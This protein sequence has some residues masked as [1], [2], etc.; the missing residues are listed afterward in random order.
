MAMSLQHFTIAIHPA[1][2]VDGCA[3]HIELLMPET[4]SVPFDPDSDSDSDPEFLPP[5]YDST[6]NNTRKTLRSSQSTN[7]Q[8]RMARRSKSLIG[9]M[10]PRTT[11]PDTPRLRRRF[12]RVSKMRGGVLGGRL[13]GLQGSRSAPSDGAAT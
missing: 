4:H 6:A 3:I 7:D 2:V 12:G 9:K 13:R 10:L 1:D 11:L 5:N 8:P